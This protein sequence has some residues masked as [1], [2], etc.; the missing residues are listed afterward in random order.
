MIT[1]DDTDITDY[2]ENLYRINLSIVTLGVLPKL[3]SN[4]SLNPEAL[5]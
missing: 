5:K 1:T 4:A 3:I 2:T